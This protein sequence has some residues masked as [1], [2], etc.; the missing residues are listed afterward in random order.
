MKI[1][2][3][4]G[5]VGAVR[6]K[7]SMTS[8]TRFF[9]LL[10][11]APTFTGLHTF[12]AYVDL[13]YRLN[14]V[15]VWVP[16][17]RERKAEIPIFTEHFLQRYSVRYGREF[18][19]ISERLMKAFLEYPWPGNVRELENM[20]KRVVVLQSEDAIADEILGQGRRMASPAEQLER[21]VTEADIEDGVSLR[22]IGRR[23]AR[24]AER[25][26]LRRVLYQTNWNR[27][28]AAKILEV[29]YKTL[30]Q[31]IKECGLSDG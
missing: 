25:E 23:A 8:A 24:D 31:K 27:K 12:F 18:R 22:E 20:V 13:F 19:P 9:I 14:V 29:S 17:L 26:A 6:R 16:P 1:T 11:S 2:P 3:G 4:K 15:N 28:K 21:I 7:S 5:L 30:L 10:D